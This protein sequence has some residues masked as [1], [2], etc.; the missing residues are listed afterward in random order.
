MHDNIHES[1]DLQIKHQQT[2]INRP[3]V[4]TAVIK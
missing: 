1:K 4:T 3:R 2:K